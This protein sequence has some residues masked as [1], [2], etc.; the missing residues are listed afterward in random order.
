MGLYIQV[1]FWEL[2]EI[3]QN[4]CKQ[5]QL[6]Q[7]D[8]DRAT[9]FLLAIT[10]YVHHMLPIFLVLFTKLFGKQTLSLIKAVNLFLKRSINVLKY[11]YIKGTLTQI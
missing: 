1:F 10:C 4:L 11:R 6:N 8:H 3:L 9:H 5:L 7:T 2:W